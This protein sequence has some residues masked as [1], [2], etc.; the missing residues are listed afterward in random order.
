[1]ETERKTAFRKLARE[2]GAMTP[3]AR[4]A[5]AAKLPVIATVEGRV[6]SVTIVYLR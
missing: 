2:I 5:L 3:E 4:A 6:L 1:M